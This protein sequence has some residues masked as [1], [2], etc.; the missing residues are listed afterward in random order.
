MRWLDLLGS[1]PPSIAVPLVLGITWQ[2]TTFIDDLT[3]CPHLLIAGSTGGGKSV[4]IRSLV[5]SIIQQ[6]SPTEVQLI[7]SDTKGVEFNDFDKSTNLLHERATTPA[8]TCEYMASLCTE[9]D[10]RMS[11]FGGAGVK[12]IREFNLSPKGETLGRLPYIVLV[13]D[14]LADILEFTE[15]EGKRTI[16]PGVEKLELHNP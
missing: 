7:L 14:E 2:G 10:Y 12:N 4:L 6:C 3:S 8:R 1:K 11:L 13:I 16:R 9:T 15:K 5:A